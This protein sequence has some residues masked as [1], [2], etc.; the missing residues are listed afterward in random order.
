ME[1]WTRTEDALPDEGIPVDTL[2][3]GGL[4][5]TLVRQGVFWYLEDRSMCVYYIPKYWREKSA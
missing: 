1:N 4:Q 2:S 3:E 5:T